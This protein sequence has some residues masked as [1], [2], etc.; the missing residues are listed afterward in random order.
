VLPPHIIEQLRK[1]EEQARRQSTEQPSLR[2]P[3]P[4]SAPLPVDPALLPVPV[5][6]ESIE[7]GVAEIQVWG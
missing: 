4:E 6:P 7:R 2:L 5:D 3:L 1:R